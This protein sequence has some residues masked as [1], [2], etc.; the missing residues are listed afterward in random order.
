MVSREELHAL[1]WSKPMTKVAEELKVSGSYLARVCSA[2]KVPR[3]ERGYWAKLA[4]GKA[5]AVRPLQ[6]ALIGDPLDWSR[7]DQPRLATKPIKPLNAIPAK[8]VKR[9][10]VSLGMHA[11]IT[12][13]R[14][15]FENSRKVD[16]WGY[17]RPYKKLLVD[18]TASRTGLI[19]A[20][21][22]SNELFNLLESGGYRVTLPHPSE[23]FRRDELDHHEVPRAKTYYE[24]NRLWWPQRPTIVYV[25]EV[26][27]GLS[28]VEMSESVLMRYVRGGRYV[29]DSEYVPPRSVRGYVD[30]SWTTTMDIPSGR[31][32][33]V[34]YA[35]HY[36]VAWSTHWQETGKTKLSQQFPGIVK[37]MHGMAEAL[38]ARLVEAHRQAEIERLARIA[39]EDRRKRKDDLTKIRQSQTQSQVHLDQIIEAWGKVMSLERF[40]VGLETHAK[41]LPPADQAALRDRLALARAF[42]GTQ[43][44]LDFFHAWQ[45]PLE[46]YQPKY[47][48]DA[49]PLAEAGDT[50]NAWD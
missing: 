37:G 4:V 1:V 12:G 36:R 45:T 16:E 24:H 27:I 43:D 33:L 8:R 28:L 50:D 5:P 13:A 41:S 2:L 48:H 44:P 25:G 22:L 10:A 14:H 9:S 39:A 29:R 26:A 49:E 15:H 34:A 35:P 46:R 23:P 40:F 19:R 47:D 7:E 6:D 31:F 17:L 32:R 30:H 3:P 11:L 21:E 20:L 38:A 18:V 42:V